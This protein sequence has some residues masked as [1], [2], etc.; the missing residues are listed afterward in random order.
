MTTHIVVYCVG[1]IYSSKQFTQRSISNKVIDG[2]QSTVA[3]YVDDNKASHVDPKVVDALLKKIRSF[4][5]EITVTRGKR[6]TFLGMDL[7][8]VNRKVKVNMKDQLLEVIDAFEVIENVEG[9][10]RSPAQHGLMV[11]DEN[12][13][14]L[15]EHRSDV[16]HSVTQKLLY[17]MKRAR[18]D[19]E[20]LLSFLTMRVSKSTVEDWKKL[21]RGLQFVLCT[22]DDERTIGATTL[23]EM[24][25]WIDAAYAVHNNMPSHTG[26]AISMGYG[27]LYG[28]SSKQKINVK[29]STE[30][31]LVG[32]CEYILY[33]IWLVIFLAAQGYEMKNNTVYQDNMSTIKM[34]NNG[35]NSCK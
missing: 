32:T 10:V 4:F 29:S 20:T 34:L 7:S 13:E 35:R 27:I 21:K 9:I 1:C 12:S 15:D 31:E 17:I 19:L 16:F 23:S 3:W 11:V 5:G 26:G 28:K 25:T 33:K 14:R 8:I 22:I 30:S 24:F 2:K 6:H 18:P